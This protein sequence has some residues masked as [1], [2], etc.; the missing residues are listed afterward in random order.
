MVNKIIYLI[1]DEETIQKLLST[2]LSKLG[3]EVKG[4]LD[5]REALKDLENNSITSKNDKTSL[6]MIDIKMP[7]I[8]GLEL[9]NRV[10]NMG[11]LQPAI[12]ISGHGDKEAAIQS[13]RLGAYDFIEK[14]F[15]MNLIEQSVKRATEMFDLE[16]E[17]MNLI[18]QL[19]EANLHLEE[20]VKERTKQLEDA[21]KQLEILSITDPLTNLYNRRYLESTLDKEFSRATR[22]KKSIS[23]LMMDT[24][25]FK[26]YNDNN[27][28]V[29]GDILLQKVSEIIKKNIRTTDFA[30]RYGGEEFTVLL[31][32]TNLVGATE[33][34]ER[35]RQ[36]IEKLELV[37]AKEQ[38]MGKISISI[39]VA[40][41][42]EITENIN[43][44]IKNADKAL[45][46]AKE[47]GRNRVV[48]ID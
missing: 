20:K 2:R 12:I 25:N 23:A 13:V 4:F 17:N 7:N 48:Y 41:Y 19:K 9:L 6:F 3:Y 8:D 40:S 34:A 37:G 1:D 31:P 45:Y 44:L 26:N 43:D 27:G 47:D 35:I 32:E 5:P 21:N 14:P 30:A 16:L 36:D 39:G 38:P 11:Y 18:N 24:D 46:K 22:Y 10:K 33:L 28:H 15:D 42:P 29:L